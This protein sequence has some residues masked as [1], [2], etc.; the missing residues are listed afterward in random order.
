MRNRY[1]IQCFEYAHSE[2][3]NLGYPSPSRKHFIYDN[4]ENY[5]IISSKYVPIV[6]NEKPKCPAY[7]TTICKALNYWW[8]HT[9]NKS[10]KG[11]L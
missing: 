4:E 9:K 3:L 7:I 11:T 10:N 8:N 2:G 1:Q 5:H 6:K